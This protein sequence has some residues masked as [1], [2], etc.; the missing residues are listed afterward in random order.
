MF[1]IMGKYKT[2]RIDE[3]DVLDECESK[4]EAAKLLT[5]YR[6][7]YGTDWI[8]FVAERNEYHEKDLFELF[9]DSSN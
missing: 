5:E 2:Q 9:S 4:E 7:A 8:I 1:L 6:M 3:M